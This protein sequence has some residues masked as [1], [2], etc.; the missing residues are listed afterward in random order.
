M[1]DREFTNESFQSFLSEHKLMGSRCATCAA[2]Y[3]PPRPLCPNCFGETMEWV[4]MGGQAT[5]RAFTV[6]AVAPSAMVAAGYGRDK[7]YC[8]GIVGLKEGPS[9]SAQ[10]VG[11]DVGQP[12]TIRIGAPVSVVY[13]ERGEGDE[14]RSYL[15][16]E[17]ASGQ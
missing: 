14:T 9:I 11:V 4:E 6:V 7:P 12:E 5:L 17:V 15:A 1:T 2:L 8:S 3:V 13:L 10:I 16:F